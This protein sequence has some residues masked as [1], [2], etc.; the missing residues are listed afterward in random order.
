MRKKKEFD[1]VAMKDK[2]QQALRAEMAGMTRE[3]RLA[4]WAREHEIFLEERK[5]IL[6]KRNA[7][8]TQRKAS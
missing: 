5:V 1:C 6:E 3:E 2:A 8:L 7:M 4:Y